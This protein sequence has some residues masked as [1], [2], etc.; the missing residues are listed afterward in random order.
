MAAW[1][2]DMGIS[3]PKP[4]TPVCYGGIFAVKRSQIAQVP[5][6][7]WRNMERSLSRGDNIEE[8]HFAER[9]WAGLLHPRLSLEVMDLLIGVS[10]DVFHV[11]E[12]MRGA[13]M[14]G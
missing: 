5:R 4:L 10:R 2:R 7:I 9:T 12:G 11:H 13:L 3:L 6:Q 1:L 8:G 14:E